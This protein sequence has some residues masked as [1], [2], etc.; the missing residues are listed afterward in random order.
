MHV[1]LNTKSEVIDMARPAH[2]VH[3]ELHSQ[4]ARCYAAATEFDIRSAND[5]DKHRTTLWVKTTDKYCKR[6]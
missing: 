2:T 1:M 3:G 5:S 4:A 6:R